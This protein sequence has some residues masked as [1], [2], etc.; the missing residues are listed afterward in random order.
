MRIAFVG[1][2]K[3]GKDFLAALI[4]KHNMEYQQIAWADSLKV[5]CSQMYPGIEKYNTPELKDVIIDEAWNVNNETTRNV[6]ERVSAEKAKV[7]NRYF[8]KITLNHIDDIIKKTD[9]NIIVTDTRNDWEYYDLKALGFMIVYIIRPN[10]PIFQ[11]YDK[12]IETFYKDITK[13]YLNDSDG[14]DILSMLDSVTAW[15]EWEYL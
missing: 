8:H 4:I 10:T 15:Y 2:K 12:R 5:H 6:W 13:K 11:G 7:D 14:M 1:S 3:S 9:D